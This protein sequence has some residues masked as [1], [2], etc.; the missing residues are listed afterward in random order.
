MQS[1]FKFADLINA[2]LSVST[3]LLIAFALM[4][5]PIAITGYFLFQSHQGAI[6]ATQKEIDGARYNETI[7][8]GQVAGARGE[9]LTEI[10]IKAIK[11]E[12]Q[13]NA[14]MIDST[15]LIAGID[16][17]GSE[18]LDATHDFMDKV[19]DASGLILDPA[20][21]SFYIMS[22]IDSDMPNAFTAAHRLYAVR[23]LNPTDAEFR[24]AQLG[25]IKAQGDTDET[26]ARFAQYISADNLSP[27][28]T[29]A[30]NNYVSAGTTFGASPTE[31]A[32]Q[33]YINSADALYLAGNRTLISLL[34]LRINHTLS[35]LTL[36]FGTAFAVMVFAGLILW[37]ISNGL[38]GR[39]RVLTDIMQKLV[40]GEE[41]GAIP[42]QDDRHETGIIVKTL[43]AF[44]SN[45]KESEDLRLMQHR[46][47][48]ESVNARHKDMLNLANEFETSI[49][50]IVDRLG[51][52]AQSLGQSA[53]ELTSDAHETSQRSGLVASSMDITSA[54]I[55]SVAGATEE[56]A[57]SSHAIADQAERAAQA[58]ANAAQKANETTKIV[59]DM[60]SAADKIGNAIQMITKITSQTNLL[61]LNATIEAARAGE[62][63]RGFSIVASEVKALAQQTAKATEEI[64]KQVKGVQEATSHAAYSITSIAEAV[65]HLR[66]IS[67]AIS[68]SVSQ[69]TEAVGEISRSTSEV[70]SS[71]SEIS[72]S[73]VQVNATANATGKRA[74]AALDEAR[75]LGDQAVALKD[76][77]LMFLSGIRAS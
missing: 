67:T 42:F 51:H 32:Y 77:S 17:Q 65:W 38:T 71:T 37:L 20:L 63:G 26:Y 3:R 21:D 1:I 34:T 56:M 64:S 24:L 13:K 44:R 6:N 5:V 43:S 29:S 49:M 59:E 62:A 57:A 14:E 55:Q 2:R 52:S 28:L 40:K 16:K 35:T 47:E 50:G 53:Q 45:L 60:N 33:D 11:E 46:L 4:I 48:E 41:V 74:Q 54:N 75:R 69:Q 15:P 8:A 73:I 36:E 7:W 12:T 31:R 39:L 10:Q 18:L 61:A 22:V 72:E 70:A 76:K 25:F 68:A 19:T 30:Y 66:D 27:E 9:G 58:A 23:N